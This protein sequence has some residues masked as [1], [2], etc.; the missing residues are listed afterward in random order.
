MYIKHEGGK[1]KYFKRICLRNFYFKK[2]SKEYAWNF[3]EALNDLKKDL[4]SK[5]NI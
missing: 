5:K 2:R 1:L 4:I 3:L